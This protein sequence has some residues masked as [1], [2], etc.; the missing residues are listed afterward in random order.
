MTETDLGTKRTCASC[1]ARFYDLGKTPLVCPKC[2]SEFSVNDAPARRRSRPAPTPTAEPKEKVAA[3][4]VEIATTVDADADDE[5]IE[6]ELAE[7]DDESDDDVIEDTSDL[8]EDDDDMAE[9][10]E[11][12]EVP[13][14]E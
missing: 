8:G 11:H 3:V 12:T 6:E 13:D 5:K 1:A 9:V 14:K 10:L 4:A 7:I 2:H